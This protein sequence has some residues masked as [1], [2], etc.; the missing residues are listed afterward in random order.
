MQETGSKNVISVQ[1]SP[2]GIL[3]NTESAGHSSEWMDAGSV[4]TAQALRQ[5]YDSAVV[6]SFTPAVTLIPSDFHI[7]GN[8]RSLLSSVAAVA[9]GDSVF[10]EPLPEFGAVLLWAPGP[11][12]PL[13]GAVAQTLRLAGCNNVRTVPE[14]FRLLGFLPGIP[15]Y[16][17]V[18]C[19]YDGN[20]LC[21]V[22]AEGKSLRLCSTFR[23]GAFTTA[24]YWIFN[25]V[26]SLQLNMEMT[27]V[28][29]ATPLSSED[30]IS[31]CSYF[32]SVETIY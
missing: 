2:R 4:F 26:K 15:K 1:V 17:K 23:A 14:V 28:F 3:I 30:E 22:I 7:K 18:L 29:F 11:E 5:S 10:S 8:E 9:D 19:S 24:E 20:T 13:A 12:A 27:D 31:L 21:L 32:R 6:S 25:A 16:N